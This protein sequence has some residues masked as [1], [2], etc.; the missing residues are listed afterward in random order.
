MK[1][2]KNIKNIKKIKKLTIDY[3]LQNAE[4]FGEDGRIISLPDP[5]KE[6]PSRPI[7]PEEPDPMLKVDFKKAVITDFDNR[8]IDGSIEGSGRY[9]LDVDINT[10]AFT[11]HHLFSREHVLAA[12][13]TA[14]FNYYVQRSKKKTV[15]FLTDKV[16]TVIA[17]T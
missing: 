8:L 10:V 3:S 11:H 16:G 17:R 6:V 12:K 14:M 4:W 2:K 7:I 13:L 9:Q 1:E 15:L 5:L